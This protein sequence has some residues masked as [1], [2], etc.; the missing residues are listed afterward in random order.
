MTTLDI[1][2]AVAIVI[3]TIKGY[4]RGLIVG[5]F[6]LLAIILGLALSMKFSSVVADYLK[7]HFNWQGVW[8]PLVSFLLV[9]IGVVFLIRLGANAIEEAVKAIMLGWLNK[10]AGIALYV[11]MFSIVFS[12]LLYYAVQFKIVSE[13]TTNTSIVYPYLK[14]IGPYVIDGLGKLI[15]F[16]KDMFNKLA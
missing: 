1:I 5:L 11:L 9:F 13:S 15:P 16:F 3:A 8:L 7:L 6:S 2:F 10:L 12:V 4:Q 14:P